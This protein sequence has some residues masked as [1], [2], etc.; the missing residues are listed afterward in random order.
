MPLFSPIPHFKKGLSSPHSK[1]LNYTSHL[2]YESFPTNF[3]ATTHTHKQT[4][5]K[6]ILGAAGLFT[7]RLSNHI[8]TSCDDV[9]HP[10]PK[11]ENTSGELITFPLAIG[12]QLANS[13]YFNTSA[14]PL[15][16]PRIRPQFLSCIVLRSCKKQFYLEFEHRTQNSCV[17]HKSSSC[18]IQLRLL[19]DPAG[20]RL[21][22]P[23]SP[24]SKLMLPSTSLQRS[25]PLGLPSLAMFLSSVF[26]ILPSILLISP[27]QALLPPEWTLF[28]LSPPMPYARL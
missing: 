17:E 21:V 4:H 16:A 23:P 6:L 15:R 18:Q 5:R 25:T 8:A 27:S 26:E 24:S 13:G 22:S 12:L 10:F 7:S 2:A 28:S 1:K 19:V 14:S 9:N 11:R 3:P 20:Q